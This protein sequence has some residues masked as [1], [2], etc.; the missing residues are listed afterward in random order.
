MLALA[1][2]PYS[3][4]ANTAL[5][6]HLVQTYPLLLLRLSFFKPTISPLLDP[7]LNHTPVYNNSAS[8]ASIASSRR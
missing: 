5:P 1:I 4:L 7:T 2:R 8:P 6:P 3:S